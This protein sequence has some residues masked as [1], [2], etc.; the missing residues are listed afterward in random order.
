MGDGG[1]RLRRRSMACQHCGRN[2]ERCSCNWGCW[3][4]RASVVVEG[5]AGVKLGCCCRLLVL[6]SF[7]YLL[8]RWLVRCTSWH[9]PNLDGPIPAFLPSFPYGCRYTVY[10]WD[11]CVR[12]LFQPDGKQHPGSRGNEKNQIWDHHRT[13]STRLWF[14]LYIYNIYLKVLGTLTY[15]NSLFLQV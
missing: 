11:I 14:S 6:A 10:S 13:T 7:D 5:V 12:S 4:A 8:A 2:I 3:G 1:Q 9:Q 15:P